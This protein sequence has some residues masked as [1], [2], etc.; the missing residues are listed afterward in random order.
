MVT[1]VMTAVYRILIIMYTGVI[2]SSP[3]NIFSIASNPFSD[4]FEVPHQ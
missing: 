1:N 3:L 4:T 2:H